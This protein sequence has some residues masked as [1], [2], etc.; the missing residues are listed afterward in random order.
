MTMLIACPHCGARSV[1]EFAFRQ[2]RPRPSHDPVQ[3]LYLRVNDPQSS[4]EYWQHVHGCRAW[5]TLARNPST[6]QI[7]SVRLMGQTS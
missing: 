2:F 4:V 1:A 7:E 5:L 6:G 3:L